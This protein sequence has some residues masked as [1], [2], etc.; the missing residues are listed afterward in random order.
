M[1]GERYQKKGEFIIQGSGGY[2]SNEW[3]KSGKGEVGEEGVTAGRATKL[4]YEE[5]AGF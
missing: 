5:H 3:C 1:D 4:G 2:M